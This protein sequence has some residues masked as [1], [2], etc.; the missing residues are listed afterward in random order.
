MVPQ[1]PRKGVSISTGVEATGSVDME[2]IGC[3]A[4]R[5]WFRSKWEVIV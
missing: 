4:D 1:K 2:G 3:E 5:C